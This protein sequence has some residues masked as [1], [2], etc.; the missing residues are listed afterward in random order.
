MPLHGRSVAMPMDCARPKAKVVSSG[1]IRG[2]SETFLGEI[3]L[4]TC[5]DLMGLKGLKPLVGICRG[6][7]TFQ[8]FC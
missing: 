3:I 7:E 4:G 6:I 8:G 5:L 2:W 1:H